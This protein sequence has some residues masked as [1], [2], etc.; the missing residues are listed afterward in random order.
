MLGNINDLKIIIFVLY[1]YTL[2]H[3]YTEVN[4]NCF[5]IYHTSRITV[6]L[7]NYC[8]F[9]SVGILYQQ[10]VRNFLILHRPLLGGE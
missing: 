1:I 6:G 10:M 2:S 5:S 8:I 3:C 7:N 4:N 9:G